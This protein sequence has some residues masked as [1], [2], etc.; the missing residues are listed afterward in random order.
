MPTFIVL[1][2]NATVGETKATIPT[3][4]KKCSKYFQRLLMAIPP[5]LV[6]VVRIGV[7]EDRFKNIRFQSF[8]SL[9]L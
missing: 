1:A 4:T 9:F 8:C 7:F 6:G 5:W 2:A 3:A